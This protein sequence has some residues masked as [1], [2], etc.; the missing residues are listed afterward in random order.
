[1]PAARKERRQVNVGIASDKE[2]RKSTAERRTC[3][4]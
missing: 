3:P 4:D 1:M 2:R